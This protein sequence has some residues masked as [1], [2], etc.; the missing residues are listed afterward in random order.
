MEQP[1][2]N[3]IR[4][5]AG[6]AVLRNGVT[7]GAY[8]LFWVVWSWPLATDPF[9]LQVAQQFDHLGTIW[10]SGLGPRL[11][12]DPVTWL[13]G[14]P[15]GEDLRRMDTLLL[16]GVSWLLGRWVA[17]TA[18]LG[19]L[20]MIGPPLSAWAAERFAAHVLSVRW[21]WSIAAGL[22]FG[23]AGPAAT[24]LLEGHSYTLLDPWLPLMAWQWHRALSPDGRLR[25]G[26]L[27]GCLWVACLLTSAYVG[28]LASLWL[29]VW[30]LGSLRNLRAAWPRVLCAAVLVLPVGVLYAAQF[31]SGGETDRLLDSYYH[32]PAVIGTIHGSA[33]LS[34]LAGAAHDAD[35]VVQHSM[36]PALGFLPWVLVALAVGRRCLTGPWRLLVVLGLFGLVFALG[37]FLR[38]DAEQSGIPWVLA[39]LQDSS[40][41]GFFR[42]PFR[43]VGLATLAWGVV[44]AAMIGLLARRSRLAPLLLLLAAVD[45]LVTN[46][47]PARMAHVGW[48]IP[49]AL[50]SLPDQGAV[51][52]LLPELNGASSEFERFLN[53]RDCAYQATLGRP[54]LNRCT[55]TT[56]R[57]G[58]RWEI[59]SWLRTALL[60]G[61]E[62]E[63]VSRRLSSLGIGAVIWR[64]DLYSPTDREVTAAALERALGAPVDTSRD[65]GEHV[66][67]YRVADPAGRDEALRTWH[68]LQ[69]GER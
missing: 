60:E 41:A 20:A 62:P 11:D 22:T 26:L 6:R 1:Q 9:R 32:Q 44:A 55:A 25:H 68:E 50:Y 49:T 5:I 8:A 69:R 19:L 37:P 17:P 52:P 16:I 67:V 31:A 40:V 30:G 56:S 10:V 7:L 59:G 21:P 53:D 43:L 24:A 47:V 64:P 4:G 54:L 29:A 63:A 27:A 45:I 28:I 61:E 14:W 39:P 18:V 58:P 48:A 36:I 42:F 51:L 3:L 38:V 46:G 2:G 13:A 33:N 57:H 12:G 66:V 23:F 34:S 35:G 15:E 65:A